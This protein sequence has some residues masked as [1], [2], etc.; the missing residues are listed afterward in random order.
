MV[1]RSSWGLLKISEWAEVATV[2]R[3]EIEKESK[4]RKEEQRRHVGISK[5]KSQIRASNGQLYICTFWC[6]NAGQQGRVESGEGTGCMDIR[7]DGRT[8][9]CMDERKLLRVPVVIKEGAK[10][11]AEVGVQTETVASVSTK[12]G[13]KVIMILLNLII[14]DLPASF[15][16][17]ASFSLSSSFS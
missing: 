14:L 13:A 7:A 1:G 16:L 3:R 17:L 9:E 10:A 5:V 11:G 2:E 15:F 12:P 4:K 6:F 8:D